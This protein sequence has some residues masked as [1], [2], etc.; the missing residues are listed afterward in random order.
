MMG[1]YLHNHYK[2]DIIKNLKTAFLMPLLNNEFSFVALVPILFYQHKKIFSQTLSI[3]L[4]I[5]F[6]L[7]CLILKCLKTRY[8]NFEIF[9]VVRFIFGQ[10]I[11]LMPR[12]AL[13]RIIYLTLIVVSVKF[14][15][16]VLLDLITSISTP[17]EIPFQYHKDL[18]NSGLQ[19]YFNNYSGTLPT[20]N[21][22]YDHDIL[23]IINKTLYIDC[24]NVIV[25]KNVSCISNRLSAAPLVKYHR[26]RDGS[27]MLKIAQPDLFI[28]ITTF[29]LWFGDASPYAMKFY[30]IIHR[31]QE[32]YL[33]QIKNSDDLKTK[34]EPP[35]IN[36][37]MKS[38][39]LII[40]VCIGYFMSIIAFIIEFIV[41]KPGKKSI[42]VYFKEVNPFSNLLICISMTQLYL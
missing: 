2:K 5:A 42:A 27:P 1:F 23:K 34:T 41:F 9:N 6:V 26:N 33:D 35:N 25:W 3:V 38:Q 37:G 29:F 32:T 30:K 24:W 7:L 11:K 39:N 21:A 17:K 36:D 18:Y 14:M 28:K 40:I 19:I 10:S 4:G 8:K 16:D 12:K 13:H 20:L 22:D 31:V 15:N